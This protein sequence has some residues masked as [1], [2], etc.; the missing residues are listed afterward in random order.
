MYPELFLV[1]AIAFAFFDQ[2][3]IRFTFIYFLIA[4][5]ALGLT[6]VKR[7]S[8]IKFKISKEIAVFWL[9]LIIQAVLSLI[10]TLSIPVSKIGLFMM[11][12]ALAY[13]GFGAAFGKLGRQRILAILFVS[14]IIFPLISLGMISKIIPLPANQSNLFVWTFGHNRIAGL[15]ILFLPASMVYVSGLISQ[16]QILTILSLS[17]PFLGLLFSGGR[18]A[19]LGF[20]SGLVYLYYFGPF[21]LKRWLKLAAIACLIPILVLMIF[22][23]VGRL[24]PNSGLMKTINSDPASYAILIKPLSNDGR[25][26]YWNGALRAIVNRPL[27]WGMETSHLVLPMFRAEGKQVSAYVHNQYLQAG[28]ELGVAGA[29]IYI[30]L[31][32]LVLLKAHQAVRADQSGLAAGIFGG[33]LASAIAAFFDYDWQYPSIYLLW[34]FLAG[35]LMMKAEQVPNINSEINLKSRWPGIMAILSVLILAYGVSSVTIKYALIVSDNSWN[36]WGKSIYPAI[37]PVAY[38]LHPELAE[39][40]LVIGL[41]RLTVDQIPKYITSNI[42]FFRQ[43]NRMLEKVLRWQEVFGSPDDVKTTARLMLDNDPQDDRASAALEKADK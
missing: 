43:D 14:S 22:P 3:S 15:L 32:L 2:T 9:F 34:W 33:I 7:L 20:L 42:L 11:L 40:S 30:L 35:T 4:V 18:T 16:W 26:D 24:W 13:F 21:N 25:L 10:N 38:R 19:L 8:G 39:R 5:G 28:V 41:R 6:A 23:I 31:I 17:I 12:S 29:V 27:G 36:S 37:A 1:S